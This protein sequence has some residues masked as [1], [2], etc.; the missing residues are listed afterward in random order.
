MIIPLL[1]FLSQ[2]EDTFLNLLTPLRLQDPIL[3]GEIFTIAFAASKPIGGVLFG[4]AFWS[5]ARR[6]KEKTIKDYMMISAFGIILLFTSDQVRGLIQVP[7]PPF[8]LVTISFM[9]IAS[10]MIL[11]GIYSSAIY[12]S[13][14][15]KL[16]RLIRNVASDSKLLDSIGSAQME[17]EI[18]RKVSPIIKKQEEYTK[19]KTWIE[20]SLTEQDV[21]QYINEVLTQLSRKRN[22][23]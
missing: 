2:F 20:A 12:V 4:I 9:A 19:E 5:V 8:G 13:Q 21:K 3:F 17:Q 15:S 22:G 11:I 10:Y 14:D 1:Y 23:T 18:L 7:Y 16:R 6:I